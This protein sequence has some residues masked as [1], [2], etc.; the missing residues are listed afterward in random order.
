MIYKKIKKTGTCFVLMIILIILSSCATKD[1]LQKNPKQVEQAKETEWPKETEKPNEAVSL[2][3]EPTN[4]PTEEPIEA[5]AFIVTK[6][7]KKI[8]PKKTVN[9]RKGPGIEYEI[10]G[11]IVLNEYMLT[12]GITENNWYEIEYEGEKGYCSGKLF[13]ESPIV[14]KKSKEVELLKPSETCE[15]SKPSEPANVN[16]QVDE[17]LT[18]VN[19]DRKANG[20][21][22]FTTSSGLQ[23][24]AN[25]R[26]QECASSFSHIRP[27]GEEFTTAFSMEGS[28]SFAEN[29]Y[30]VSANTTA[31]DVEAAW[32]NSAGH[33]AN[34]LNAEYLYIG[35]GIYQASNGYWYFVQ[36]FTN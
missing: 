32:M 34:I 18:A 29:I 12:T 25:I 36:D 31:A 35:I 28:T 17:L 9:V 14:E 20:L 5:S 23:K 24:T 26:A 27:N 2:I 8:Y 22:A 15:P 16:V 13:S 4:F 10:F 3:Q 7:S 1:S 30:M 21:A 19:A 11:T 33:R 6:F